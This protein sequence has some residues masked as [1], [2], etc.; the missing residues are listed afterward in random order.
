M[1]KKYS[2]DRTSVDSSNNRENESSE[3]EDN[4]DD[5]D[6]EELDGINVYQQLSMTLS[7]NDMKVFKKH[8]SGI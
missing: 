7:L 8:L 3:D 4:E 5:E 6:D 2:M 1:K